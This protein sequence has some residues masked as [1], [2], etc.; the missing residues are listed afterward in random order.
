LGLPYVRIANAVPFDVS[1]DAPLCFF[2]WEHSDSA[3]ALK[4]NLEG[5]EVF[6]KL[7]EPSL[8]V[9]KQYAGEKHPDMGDRERDRSWIEGVPARESSDGL[10]N[11]L[12]SR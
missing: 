10:D 5:I 7:L 4:R 1:G 2:D 6:R 8:K 11:H 9:A 12:E 3:K